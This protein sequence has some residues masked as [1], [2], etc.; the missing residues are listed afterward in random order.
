MVR[1]L[2]KLGLLV[3]AL[4]VFVFWVLPGVRGF[5]E[6]TKRLNECRKRC[7]VAALAKVDECERDQAA[8]PVGSPAAC[9]GVYQE[10]QK[11]CV[12]KCKTR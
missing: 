1:T 12:E 7:D 9:M 5:Q 2:V 4:A 3:A 10:E 11:A 6:D 8:G